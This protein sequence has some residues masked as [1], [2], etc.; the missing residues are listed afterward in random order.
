MEHES[1]RSERLT[2]ATENRLLTQERY[3]E[4]L[5]E[6]AWQRLCKV[7]DYGED[8]YY[9]HGK[10]FDHWMCFSDVYRKFIRLQTLTRRA[11]QEEEPQNESL[12]DTYRDIANYAIM[13]VQILEKY[14]ED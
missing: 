3:E 9:N 14:Y 12:L 10:D 5:E 8:R 13:A 6:L 1:K 11:V 7:I 2:I 4:L